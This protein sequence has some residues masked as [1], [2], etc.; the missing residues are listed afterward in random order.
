[1]ASSSLM[2]GLKGFTIIELLVTI[3]IFAILA[4]F[5][6][7]S[8]QQ[9]LAAQRI[10]SAAYELN[11]SLAQARY[12][13]SMQRLDLEL[14]AL[15]GSGS[16]WKPTRSSTTAQIDWVLQPVNNATATDRLSQTSIDR[17]ISIRTNLDTAEGHRIV[18]LPNGH[19]AFANAARSRMADVTFR[20]CDNAIPA[21]DGYTVL[22]NRFG[23]S[24]VIRGKLASGF[25]ASSCT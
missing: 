15:N 3:S 1:M 12:Q 7:P 4:S 11:S 17:R 9:T 18:F 19:I 22:L 14:L 8:I 10:K 5:A 24:R 23:T 25:G 2:K 20:I 16:T 13:S 6:A 21:D